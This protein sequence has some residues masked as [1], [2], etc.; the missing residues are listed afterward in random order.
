MT[1]HGQR[2]VFLDLETGGL[3]PKRHPIIQFAAVA[4]DEELRELDLIEIKVQFTERTATKASLRKNHYSRGL[5]RREA[6][7]PKAAA[8]ELAAFLRHYATSEYLR[9]DGTVAH[10]AQLVAHNGVAF[11]GPFL[12]TWFEGLGI[13]CPAKRHVLCT[14]QR[15]MWYFAERPSLPKPDSFKLLTLCRYFGVPL[16][17][18]EA[19]DALADVRATIGLYRALR[20]AERSSAAKPRPRDYQRQRASLSAAAS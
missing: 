3:N 13:Y 1:E 15:A 16:H 10:L 8:R 14:M 19:H 11:D 4:V 2:L 5:W 6:M 12:Q 20:E 9:E 18:F 7:E 17:P